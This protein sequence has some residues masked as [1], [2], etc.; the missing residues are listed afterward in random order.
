[1]TRALRFLTPVL[2]LLLAVS[3]TPHGVT[4][5]D[6][7]SPGVVGSSVPQSPADSVSS[8]LTTPGAAASVVIRPG[9][10]A[11]TSTAVDSSLSI[12]SDALEVLPLRLSVGE[13]ARFPVLNYAVKVLAENVCLR[14]AR[15]AT[16]SRCHTPSL[17]GPP[18]PAYPFGQSLEYVPHHEKRPD[19]VDL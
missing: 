11:V 3:S 4:A 1:M 2:V 7:P 18:V 12:Q 6:L 9:W 13:R 14:S 10:A 16:P 5:Q 17:N 15:F 8:A 19:D